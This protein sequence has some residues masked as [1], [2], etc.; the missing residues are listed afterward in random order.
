MENT[1][2]YAT[3]HA[4]APH[5]PIKKF[6]SSV[7]RIPDEQTH[8]DNQV[9]SLEE[10]KNKLINALKVTKTLKAFF[11]Q[12]TTQGEA[13]LVK[14]G[15]LFLSRPGKLRMVIDQ[16][17]QE[18]LLIKDKWLIHEVPL[19]NE[20]THLPLQD[21]PAHILLEKESTLVQRLK[22]A[23]LSHDSKSL[24][25]HFLYHA[26]GLKGQFI[27]SFDRTTYVL[28]QWTVLDGSGQETRVQLFQ[29]EINCP[30]DSKI[31]IFQKVL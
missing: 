31:F 17:Q 27:L 9:V 29:V 8:K 13:T 19:M 6:Q 7:K 1:N 18:T 28:K 24:H 20:V 3:T 30:I 5:H 15:T 4:N 22:K 26:H 25:V 14:K 10:E 12:T 21:T 23:E 11:Q 2:L 16:P